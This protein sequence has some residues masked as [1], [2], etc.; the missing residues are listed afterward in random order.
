MIR[1]IVR[2]WLS[3]GRFLP[4]DSGEGQAVMSEVSRSFGGRPSGS[5]SPRAPDP[6]R[7]GVARPV[8]LVLVMIMDLL[9]FF[10]KCCLLVLTV[11]G[12]YDLAVYGNLFPHPPSDWVKFVG[13]AQ[14]ASSQLDEAAIGLKY[15][16]HDLIAS[17]NS[18]LQLANQI[19]D[20]QLTGQAPN[21]TPVPSSD[22]PAP[23]VRVDVAEPRAE[24]AKPLTEKKEEQDRKNKVGV[25]RKNPAKAVPNS[26]NPIQ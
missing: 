11:G 18:A 16:T 23:Q 5:R 17:I 2:D 13:D 20:K 22:A 3:T 9:R 25:A 24:A 6:Q 12:A 15:A 10:L 21:V 7:P 8:A 14:E 4:R 26:D 1:G 19:A